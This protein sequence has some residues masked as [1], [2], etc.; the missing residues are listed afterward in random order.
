ME[1]G[2][3]YPK[4]IGKFQNQIKTT[5]T[6]REKEREREKNILEK[7]K[8]GWQWPTERISSVA[9]GFFFLLAEFDVKRSLGFFFYPSLSPYCSIAR[10][11]FRERKR[12]EGGVW[13]VFSNNH[14]QFLNNISSISTHFFTHTYFHKYFQT[15][16]FNF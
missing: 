7:L 10:G 16:I 1:I 6:H 4:I 9:Q 8:R 15:T 14:F 2:E 3:T 12:Y 11:F 5:K 13:F